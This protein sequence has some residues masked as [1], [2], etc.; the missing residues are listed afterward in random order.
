MRCPW[1]GSPVTIRGNR[2]E[3]GRCG[4][5]G[6]IQR[7]KNR[8]LQKAPEASEN[9]EE[10]D[11]DSLAIWE[12][13]KKAM[14]KA[15]P[16]RAEFLLPD[17]AR[18]IVCQV[19]RALD[20]RLTPLPQ[21]KQEK[22]GGLLHVLGT[23]A[24]LPELEQILRGDDW[25]TSIFQVKGRL[26]TEFCG[27]FWQNFL[28]HR[29]AIDYPEGMD[30]LF[31]NLSRIYAYYA[32]REYWQCKEALWTAFE[33]HWCQKK[34]F[35]PD[36]EGAKTRLRYDDISRFEDDCRDILVSEFPD[37]FK[38]YS[39]EDMENLSWDFA[40]RECLYSDPP[41]A[42]E[43]WR[44][45]LD[46]AGPRLWDNPQVS[47]KFRQASMFPEGL[48]RVYFGEYYEPPRTVIRTLD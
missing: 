10:L 43:M 47:A 36:A 11:V 27:T 3:C 25:Q 48:W 9:G 2:W 8:N 19:R 6:E 14:G 35:T 39:L 38:G 7:R 33:H 34:F 20:S 37:Y 15:L 4:D 18:T 26:N 31:E 24:Q 1:C 44:A 42:V 16:G 29:D 32:D 5:F 41:Q 17:L 22:L 13:L 28:P 12:K 40:L 23:S 45:L 46:A 30:E 21:C